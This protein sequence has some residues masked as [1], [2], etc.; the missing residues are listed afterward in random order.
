MNRADRRALGIPANEVPDLGALA[1][2]P[3]P[4]T[5]N[6]GLAAII[7]HLPANGQPFDGAVMDGESLSQ[8]VR[9]VVREEL[10]RPQTPECTEQRH[11]VSGTARECAC[12]LLRV[13]GAVGG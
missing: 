1:A 6:I 7:A 9:S 13:V 5:V 11:V 2:P 12:G 4:Q 3:R 10:D 8:M